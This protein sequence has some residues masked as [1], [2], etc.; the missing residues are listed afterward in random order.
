[1]HV[2]RVCISRYGPLQPLDETLAPFTV[3]HGPNERGKTLLIDALVRMLFKD[4]LKRSHYKLFGNLT[5]VDE[6]PEGF[7]VVTTHAGETKIGAEESLADVA[8]VAISPEDFRNV[9]LIRD[10]DLA[11]NDEEAYYGR[12]SERLCGTSSTAIDRLKDALKRIGRLRSASPDS[13]LTVRKDRDQ[14]RIGEQVTAAERLIDRMVELGGALER[15][16]FDVSSRRLAELAEVRERCEGELRTLRAAETRTRLENARRAVEETRADLATL[17]TLANADDAQL[18][19]WRGLLV[20]REL[21]EKDLADAVARGEEVRA[22]RD[23]AMSAWESMR[24]AAAGALRDR[25]QGELRPL[26]EAWQLERRD[27]EHAEHATRALVA[28]TV[29]SSVLGVAAVV[30]ALLFQSPIAVGAAVACVAAAGWCGALL[31]RGSRTRAGL[32]R[33]EA[34]LLAVAARLGL[35]AGSVAGVEEAI[36]A[37]ERDAAQAVE[38]ARDAEVQ[39]RQ[40]ESDV[41]AI[42]RNEADR[43]AGIAT[44]HAALESL[45]AASGFETVELLEVAVEKRRGLENGI[46]ARLT[47]LRGWIPAALRAADRDGFLRV[48]EAEAMRGLEALPA[49]VTEADPDAVA[50]AEAELVRITDDER[51]LRQR[52]EKTRRDLDAIKVRIADLG[53]LEPPVNC[54]TARELET[55]RLHLLEFCESVQRDARLAKEAIRIVQEIEAE[56]DEKVGELFGEG[57]L[58]SRWFRDITGGRYRAVHLE[59]GEIVVELADG[60]RLPARALSGGAFDQLYVAIRASIAERMLPDTKGFFILD[61]PFLKAD[62]ERMRSLMKMLRNLVGRGWQVIYVTAKDEVVE[63]LQADIASGA[64]HLIELERS[65]FARGVPRA[66]TRIPDAPRLL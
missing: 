43:R 21:L 42:E 44:T 33:R 45:R 54:R 7:V 49:E 50:R 30:F 52:L 58:V 55:A 14:K 37:L 24:A 22:A 63:A 19:A 27:R 48:C 66:T 46:G 32:V 18:A 56:E 29:V 23:E 51:A 40:R 34:E 38:R 11:L 9:F 10:S 28:V 1:M 6:R 62:R 59:D 13:P 5:R 35:A 61:D 25:A 26:L 20:K 47:L 65:L 39:V 41:A 2:K 31:V 57:T 64:V 36:D 3:I 12:V 53:V 16:G 17:A 15:D 8:P 60:K 4:G